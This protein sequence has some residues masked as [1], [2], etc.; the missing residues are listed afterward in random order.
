MWDEFSATLE[1]SYKAA[2]GYKVNKADWLEGRWAGLK[3]ADQEG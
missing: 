3:A 1:E 2:Q